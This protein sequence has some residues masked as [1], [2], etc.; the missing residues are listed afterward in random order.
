ME[1][2]F[3]AGEGERS[4]EA[5]S[6]S[7]SI[8]AGV[9]LCWLVHHKGYAATWNRLLAESG[10]EWEGGAQFWTVMARISPDGGHE[11]AAGDGRA[12]AW[13]SQFRTALRNRQKALFIFQRFI[14]RTQQ[15]IRAAA[16]PPGREFRREISGNS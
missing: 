5:R 12:T 8:F 3:P 2:S 6:L 15:A 10:S 1:S 14:S 4:A 11:I 16:H 9:R 13:N 7:S